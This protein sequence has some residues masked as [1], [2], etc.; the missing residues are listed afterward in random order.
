MLMGF[1]I[2]I[3]AIMHRLTIQNKRANYWLPF[4]V[5][6]FSIAFLMTWTPFNFWKWL[7]HIFFVGQYNWRLLGQVIWIGAL[8]FGW[9]ICWL[10]KNKLDLRHTVIGILLIVISTSAYFPTINNSN[11]NLTEFLQKP[12]LIYN[13]TTYSI[14]FIKNPQFVKHIDTMNIDLLMLGNRLHFNE[15]YA[16][17]KALLD[18]AYK[19]IIEVEGIIPIDIKEQYMIA[20][21]ND[22]EIA[23]F[24]FKKT[25]KFHWTFPLSYKDASFQNTDKFHFQF[26]IVDPT[27]EI[28]PVIPIEKMYISGFASPLDTMDVVDVKKHCQLNKAITHCEL[29]IGKDIKILELPILYYPK[30]LQIKLNGKVVPYYGVMKGSYL[31]AGITPEPS[32]ANKVDIEFRGL[33]WANLLS[34]IFWSIWGILLLKIIYEIISI[35]IHF[36]NVKLAAYI[37]NTK[38]E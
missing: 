17:T 32:T 36:R 7:P 4:F 28:P 29:N 6:L 31:L 38:M 11:I 1:V 35:R 37:Q 18:Y 34:F 26:K 13:N 23:R 21:L 14:N 33:V 16:I 27:T 24:T 25:G 12:L 15:K 8:L 2:S 22:Q 5:I 3:Y 20:L 19:P 30:L 10:F 9:G